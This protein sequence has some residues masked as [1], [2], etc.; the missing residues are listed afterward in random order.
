VKFIDF[1]SDT[2]TEPTPK[3][4][5]AMREAEVG[6]DVYED[7][8]TVK[9]LEEKAAEIMGKQNALFVPTGTFGNQLAILTS[10]QRGDEVI[11]G[12]NNHIVVHEV[13]AAALISSVNM[14]TLNDDF[15]SLDISSLRLA[16][17]EDDIHY[18]RTSLICMENAHGLGKV[19]P[20]SNMRDVYAFAQEKNIL[21]HLDGARIFNAASYL[22]IEPKEITKYC[23]SVMF[24]L[25]KGLCCPIGSILASDSS[26]IQK[27]RKNRKLLGGGMRQAGYLAA[28]G[29]VALQ[30][31]VKRIHEDHENAVYL[32]ERLN[33]LEIFEVFF[34]RLEEN[35]VYCK[36]IM[37][38]RLDE[39]SLINYLY[40]N[41]VKI[42]P[43]FEG[44][45]RFVT[46]YWINKE[47][48]DQF[49]SLIERFITNKKPFVS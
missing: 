37:S 38:K 13:G 19:V 47:K 25:S 9:K 24:C 43:L 22:K 20:L 28:C 40:E 33:E 11:I 32:A 8:I 29:L 35:M 27:A 26:F 12:V 48:I 7:D 30:D 31:M 34:E 14:R 1:R 17:R 10:T 5:D 23:D 4:L 18:P 2:V 46:H 16:F 15:G 21:L 49:I 41:N 42:S 39:D 6:D 45:Y 44:T 3:M 36:P